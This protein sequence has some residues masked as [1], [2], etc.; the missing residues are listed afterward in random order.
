MIRTVCLTIALVI[1]CC[2]LSPVFSIE[3]IET[4]LQS[5]K[6]QLLKVSFD[7]REGSKQ[8]SD[9]E[10]VFQLKRNLDF[11]QFIFSGSY[12][13][14]TSED[15]DIED[16]LF[17]HTRVILKSNWEAFI[18]SQYDAFDELKKRSIIGGGYRF[19]YPMTH[20]TYA[21]LGLGLLL[22]EERFNLKA[23]DHNW[24]L[25]L[26]S[27]FVLGH[28]FSES[29][30]LLWVFY[31]QASPDNT[32]HFRLLSDLSLTFSITESLSASSS[33]IYRHNTEVIPNVSKDETKIKQGLLWQF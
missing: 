19:N 20:S 21:M 25:R 7:Y 33:F 13:K 29:T 17:L 5:D 18:Q 2:F 6:E 22:E 26:R 24:R 30:K 12:D 9:S 10:V 14:Q 28:D 27:S 8:K 31:L 15:D 23:Y 16:A 4:L 3:N 1:I 11:G 32:S